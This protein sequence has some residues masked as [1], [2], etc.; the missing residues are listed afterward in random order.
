MPWSAGAIVATYARLP[1]AELYNVSGSGIGAGF[2]R[3]LVFVNYSGALAAIAVSAVAAESLFAAGRS[4]VLVG[5]TAAAAIVLCATVA[6]PGVV[7]QG[8][9]DA[10]SIK[11]HAG[12]RRDDRRCPDRRDGAVRA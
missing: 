3:A 10:R 8:D 9:L 6:G 11:C 5:A 4:R 7:D 2:G 1:A 12:H